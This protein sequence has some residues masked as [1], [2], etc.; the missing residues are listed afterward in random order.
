[1]VLINNVKHALTVAHTIMPF[2]RFITVSQELPAH[3][4]PAV[5]IKRKHKHNRAA[6]LVHTSV[7]HCI[8]N[9][10]YTLAMRVI[11]FTYVDPAS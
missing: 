5:L 8:Y 11:Q 3:L 2:N 1:M 9:V 7:I 10:H 4:S 6:L